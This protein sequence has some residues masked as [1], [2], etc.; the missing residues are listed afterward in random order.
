MTT[1]DD[2]LDFTEVKKQHD[3]KAESLRALRLL[4]NTLGQTPLRARQPQRK[5]RA[6]KVRLTY[7]QRV[8]VD[9]TSKAD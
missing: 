7:E 9:E 8:A 5:K 2:I 1:E 3:A 4:K 6:V